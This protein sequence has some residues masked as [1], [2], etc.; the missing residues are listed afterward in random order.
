MIQING[1]FVYS[2]SV[3]VCLCVLA[4]LQG[5]RLSAG[6]DRFV[7]VAYLTRSI[8]CV[9]APQIKIA[10]QRGHNVPRLALIR[11]QCV[12]VCAEHFLKTEPLT[13]IMIF[14]FYFFFPGGECMDKREVKLQFNQ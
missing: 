13:A 1:L 4:V 2:N 5:H 8:P 9:R 3:G 14:Y 11:T 10:P 7:G 12:C 6:L